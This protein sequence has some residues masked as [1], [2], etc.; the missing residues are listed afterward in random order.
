M[1]S[2]NERGQF[3][4]VLDIATDE[5]KTVYL[6]LRKL[7][8][9][10][11]PRFCEVVW[12]KLKI[13]SFGVGPKK[14]TQHYAYIAVYGSHINLGFYHGASLPDPDHVL[15]G[16]GKGLRHVKIREVGALKSK[17][18]KALLVGAI[19]DRRPYATEA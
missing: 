4:H 13:A 7:I 1:D 12:P 14:M 9:T 18:I 6:A 19:A 5:L 17:A 10:L 8:T 11:D 2:K 16:G 15:E 3:E